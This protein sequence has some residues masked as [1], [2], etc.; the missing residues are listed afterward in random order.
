[1]GIWSACWPNRICVLVI[2]HTIILPF[3]LDNLDQILI[4]VEDL[5]Y[6]RWWSVTNQVG[7]EP[8]H[9]YPQASVFC[10]TPPV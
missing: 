1:M 7:L 2:L 3:W 4:E 6:P 9:L 8:K 10:V 5:T